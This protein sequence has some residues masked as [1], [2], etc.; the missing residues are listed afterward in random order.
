MVNPPCEF[1][2]VD[3]SV[4]IALNLLFAFWS[5]LSLYCHTLHSSIIFLHDNR[6]PP[7]VDLIKPLAVF[8]VLDDTGI[9]RHCKCIINWQLCSTRYDC[10]QVLSILATT[11]CLR[12]SLRLTGPIDASRA[13]DSTTECTACC[14]CLPTLI[15]VSNVKIT[16]TSTV[17][18]SCVGHQDLGTNLIWLVSA[19]ISGLPVGCIFGTVQFNFTS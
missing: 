19:Q 2:L 17:K 12:P 18:V 11:H 6:A 10:I 9:R 14:S 3:T 13:P 5:Y 16:S 15:N 7:I 8:Y 1:I 4:E